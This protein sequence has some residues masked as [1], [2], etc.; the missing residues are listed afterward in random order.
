LEEF[1]CGLALSKKVHKEFIIPAMRELY[2]KHADEQN[3]KD[4][5]AQNAFI[6]DHVKIQ[7][8]P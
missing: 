8:E 2:S 7:V 4:Y 1:Y 3:K 6:C 5:I